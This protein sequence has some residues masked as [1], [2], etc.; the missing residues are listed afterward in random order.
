M[1][2]NVNENTKIVSVW[3]TGTEKRDAALRERLKPMYRR[4]H[5]EK[6]LVAVYESGEQSLESLKSLTSDLLCYNRKRL[7]ELEVQSEKASA[8]TMTI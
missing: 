7:A 1:E 6:Y 5:K 4:Y 3:L 8:M 2:I